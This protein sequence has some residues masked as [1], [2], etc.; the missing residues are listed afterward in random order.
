MYKKNVNYLSILRPVIILNRD[1]DD[2]IGEKIISYIPFL[3]KINFKDYCNF[4]AY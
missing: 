1:N 3:P 4:Y 2:R